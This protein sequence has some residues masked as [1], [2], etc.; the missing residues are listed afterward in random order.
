V[1]IVGEFQRDDRASNLR[2][3]LRHIAIYERVVGSRR[4]AS[5]PLMI[6]DA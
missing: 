2:C 5:M 4:D 1:L 6:T 3:H